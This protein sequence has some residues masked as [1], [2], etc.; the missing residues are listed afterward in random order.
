MS[1]DN[2]VNNPTSSS[3]SIYP[4][5]AELEA[6][7]EARLELQKTQGMA[8]TSG[9]P[10]IAKGVESVSVQNETDSTA[11]TTSAPTLD[12]PTGAGKA[13]SVTITPEAQVEALMKLR[14]KVSSIL[15]YLNDPAS[16]RV[17][18]NALA[19]R[20]N[21]PDVASTIELANEVAQGQGGT[22]IQPDRLS[23][24]KQESLSNV[25]ALLAQIISEIDKQEQTSRSISQADAQT[26]IKYQ[27]ASQEQSHQQADDTIN[28]AKASGW[29]Q[30]GMALTTVALTAGISAMGGEDGELSDAAQEQVELE[31]QE[32]ALQEPIKAQEEE[33]NRIGR[34][35]TD[36]QKEIE[37]TEQKIADN[38]QRIDAA[39]ENEDQDPFALHE[40]QDNL[41]EKQALQD[42]LNEKQTKLAQAQEKQAQ[43]KT[44]WDKAVAK[45]K[46]PETQK[47][48]EKIQAKKAAYEEAYEKATPEQQA[49]A[50]AAQAKY[51]AANKAE[52]T[53]LMETSK[54]LQAERMRQQS[55][56][57]QTRLQYVGTFG[58][59]GQPFATMAG[60]GYQAD[61]I[62]DQAQAQLDATTS[63]TYSAY[64]SN[65][66]QLISEASQRTQKVLG[67]IDAIVQN[68]YNSA[69]F[70]NWTA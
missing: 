52:R 28:A 29:T 10:K 12:R 20:I 11:P 9:K 61:S 25:L 57:Q 33:Y 13:S 41:N 53:K 56:K 37:D 49:E 18:V 51:K 32:A 42:D 4:T 39:D 48:L 43:A 31:Q 50:D 17:G 69:I 27:E 38:Q 21:S 47:N 63:Q 24:I 3:S 36:T 8:E 1:G 44:D 65:E 5:P 66:N 40:L 59:L 68:L 46:E 45:A 2:S 55:I 34:E 6:Q 64:Q 7:E 70:R 16:D 30:I 67:A 35:V 23:Q 60:A 26:Q 62:N 58:Q 54:M 14:G 15:N 22:Q 19:V